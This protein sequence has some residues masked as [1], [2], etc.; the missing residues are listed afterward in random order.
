M[1]ICYVEIFGKLCYIGWM[2]GDEFFDVDC[3]LVVEFDLVLY[4]FEVVDKGGVIEGWLILWGVSY[5]EILCVE[6]VECFW[7]GYDCDVV[8]C[9]NV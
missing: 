3:Y 4:W 9:G 1:F 2:C 8:S 6:K 7:V 5:L